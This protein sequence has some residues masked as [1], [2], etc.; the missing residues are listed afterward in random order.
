[1]FASYDKNV[2]V[3]YD[4]YMQHWS[5]VTH[6][7]KLCQSAE[8]NKLNKAT[9]LN[10]KNGFSMIYWEDFQKYYTEL[11]YLTHWL[12]G[13]LTVIVLSLQIDIMSISHKL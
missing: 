2:V 11:L 13:D 6:G 10:N 5:M 1:M 9:I 3:F 12:W 8:S 7:L 4:V